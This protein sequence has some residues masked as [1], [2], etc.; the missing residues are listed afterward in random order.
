MAVVGSVYW[1]ANLVR[2]FAGL[3]ALGGV[4]DIDGERAR[5][6]AC[7]YGGVPTD[8][9]TA[10][11]WES[12]AIDAVAIAVPAELHH[13][14]AAAIKSFFERRELRHGSIRSDTQDRC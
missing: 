7:Q 6:L 14:V 10:E 9:S 11:V 4:C 2:N 13:E 8:G 3:G 1:G 5:E 12:E